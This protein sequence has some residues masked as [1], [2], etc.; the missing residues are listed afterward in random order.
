MSMICLLLF[1][2]RYLQADSWKI[3]SA[4]DDKTLKVR[5]YVKHAKAIFLVL[6]LC[7]CGV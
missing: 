3:V 2:C 6:Q 4:A 5:T 7:R 1:D